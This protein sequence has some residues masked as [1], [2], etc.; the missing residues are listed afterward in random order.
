MRHA[1]NGKDL[2]RMGHKSSERVTREIRVSA[3]PR[4][5]PKHS[6]P[7]NSQYVYAYR[8]LIEN[9]GRRTVMVASRHWVI[10]DTDGNREVVDGIGVV[11]EQPVL[12]PGESFEY[13]SFCPIRSSFGT[14]E[15][16]FH[17]LDDQG[18]AFPVEIGRFYLVAEE[19]EQLE[20]V[21]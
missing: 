15:G 6:D 11:G 9:L 13:T 18:E 7:D 20:G 5:L 2:A 3:D 8:I 19:D 14:M 10:I 12:E 1:W 17:V 4:Y 21:S 16:S